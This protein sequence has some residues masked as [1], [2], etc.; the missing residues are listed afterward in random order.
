MKELSSFTS[1]SSLN[2][3]KGWFIYMCDRI[4]TGERIKEARENLGFTQEQLGQKIGVNKSTIQRYETGK[5]NKLKLPVIQSIAKALLVNPE[6]LTLQSEKR[7]AITSPSDVD[8]DMF[9][10]YMYKKL[11]A[12]DRAEIRGEMKQMLKAEKYQESTVFI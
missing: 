7:E 5:I 10:L 8:P 11:D 2:K 3:V 6:W 4:K 12:E 1:N 9:V